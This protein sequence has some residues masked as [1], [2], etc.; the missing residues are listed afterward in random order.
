MDCSNGNF[1][2]SCSVNISVNKLCLF[3]RIA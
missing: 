1:K 2:L 3:I